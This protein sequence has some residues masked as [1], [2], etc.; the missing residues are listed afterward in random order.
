MGFVPSQKQQECDFLT[1]FSCVNVSLR[2]TKSVCTKI[3]YNI[4][5]MITMEIIILYIMKRF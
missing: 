3:Y 5:N 2:W 4:I 1:V